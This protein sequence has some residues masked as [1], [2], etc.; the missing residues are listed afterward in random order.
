MEFDEI[1]VDLFED[2]RKM[3]ALQNLNN[4]TRHQ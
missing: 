4:E 3:K 1:N 2:Y